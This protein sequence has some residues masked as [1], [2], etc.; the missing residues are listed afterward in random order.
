VVH[1]EVKI[2]HEVDHPNCVK[3]FEIFETKKKLFMVM[4]LLTV[5][6]RA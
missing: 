1:D 6:A 3:L 2:M 5:S 4:E